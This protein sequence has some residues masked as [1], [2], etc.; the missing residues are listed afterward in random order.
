[1]SRL[2]VIAF[3][4]VD[5]PACAGFA[6][7]IGL[8]FDVLL[9]TG[10][11]SATGAEKTLTA[12]WSE[13]PA[14]DGYGLAA[15]AS[16]YSHIAAPSSMRSKEVFGRLAGQMDCGMLSD[17]TEVVS[18]TVY[19]RPV[20]AG[21]LV[22]EV[23]VMAEPVV[24][25]FRPAGFSGEAADAAGEAV[26]MSQPSQVEIISR[27]AP[28]GARPDLGQAKVVV[29][30]GQPLGDAETFERIIGALADKLGGAVG[31]T[32]AAVDSGIAANEMQVGQTGKIVAPEL[33]IA[34]GISGSTQH[35]AGIKD[36]RLIVAI[37]TDADAPIF[38]V[39]DIGLVADL[40]Q[41]VPALTSKAQRP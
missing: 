30:G 1:M 31:A 29:S 21:S 11:G 40:F 36:S 41:A 13:L 4:P 9:L 27:A 8:P 34:A 3:S 33:Y 19:R 28:S 25:T 5:L 18:P 32:R 38:R 12:G 23:E 17:V 39:A 14:G 24:I 15:L 26:D 6:S 16:G 37:N 22:A 20:A 35:L 10:S 7:A 2:L